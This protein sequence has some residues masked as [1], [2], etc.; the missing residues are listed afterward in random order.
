MT[1]N[2]YKILYFRSDLKS[3]ILTRGDDLKFVAA[4][5]SFDQELSEVQFVLM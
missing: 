4:I 5:E 2:G 3:W 1:V